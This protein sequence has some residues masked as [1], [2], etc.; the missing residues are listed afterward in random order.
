MARGT[1]FQQVVYGVATAAVVA[2]VAASGCGK[3]APKGLSY[4]DALQIYNDE[5]RALDRLKEQRA[6]LQAA[7]R[8]SA[9]DREHRSG[10]TDLGKYH[11][12][13]TAALGCTER[14]WRSGQSTC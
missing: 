4:A 10:R 3:A 14:P 1:R 8:Q 9:G 13:V 7:A 11:G 12:P 2:S 6:E 5:T